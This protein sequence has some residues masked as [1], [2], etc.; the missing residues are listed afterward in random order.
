LTYEWDLDNDAVFET[1]GPTPAF[2]AAGLDGPSSHPVALKVCDPFGLC[3]TDSAVVNVL[4]V[5]PTADAGA[6]QTVYRFDPVNV[7]GSWTD[8]AGALDD[9]YSWSWDL[10]GDGTA[11]ASGSASFGDTIAQTTS[12]ALEGFYTLTFEVTDKDGG[13]DSDTV[14]IEVLNRPPDCSAVSPSIDL[15]WPANHKFVDI[16]VLGVTDPEG[17]TITITIDSIFQDEPLDDAGDGAFEPDGQGVGTSIAQV[18]AE[19]AGTK[20]VPGNGRFYHI[21]FTADDGHGGSCSSEVLVAVPHDQKKNAAPVDDG[22]L[23]DSTV[24]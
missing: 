13:A 9:P 16:E 4:N 21:S 18:R 10:D 23:Y 1:F 3:D 17:D 14:V 15:L 12:F 11:N 22:P 7:T 24:P 8:P 2:S 5:A 19:R 6:D 20:K